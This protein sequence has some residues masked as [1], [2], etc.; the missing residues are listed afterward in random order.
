MSDH[1]GLE[2]FILNITLFNITARFDISGQVAAFILYMESIY[3]S[4]SNTLYS[5]CYKLR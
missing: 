4:Y 2:D 5:G 3:K 1:V